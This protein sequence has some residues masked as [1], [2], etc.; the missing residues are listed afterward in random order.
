M[1]RSVPEWIG[2]TPD[3]PIPARV[4]VRVFEA[5]G[6]VCYLSK[7]KIRPGEK[8]EC[9]HVIALVNGGENRERNLAPALAEPHREKTDADMALKSKIARVRAKHLGQW[10]KSK[11][12]LRSRGFEKA[13][14]T[15]TALDDARW[16]GADEIGGMHKK[17][18]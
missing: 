18:Q 8:W 16:D 5:H 15:T 11:R 6:G 14:R 2:S 9:E 7:R 1:T 4:R 17:D 3:T 12:P 13:R 10:P